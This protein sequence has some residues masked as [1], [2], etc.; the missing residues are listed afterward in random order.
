MILMS[1]GLLPACT[2]FVLAWAGATESLRY[3][4]TTAWEWGHPSIGE[5]VLMF[6][7]VITWTWVKGFMNLFL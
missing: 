6:L 4:S 5:V 3:I 1:M 7:S 2:F